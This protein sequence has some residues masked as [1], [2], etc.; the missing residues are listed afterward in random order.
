M[1]VEIEK[2]D[3]GRSIAEVPALPGAMGYGTSKSPLP[4]TSRV[5][6]AAGESAASV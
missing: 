1:Q 4:I 5:F 2:K 3:D 6:T